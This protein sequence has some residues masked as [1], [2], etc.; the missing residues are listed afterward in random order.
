MKTMKK[1]ASLLLA[2]AMIFAL[3]TTAFA[4]DDVNGT[5]TIKPP[6]GIDDDALNTY[7]IY[8]VFDAAAHGD[9]ISYKRVT[10]K[11]DVPAGFNV[12]DAGNVT[13]AGAEGTTELTSADIAAIADYVKN[14]DPVAIVKSTGSANAVAENLGAG[15][16]YITTTTGTAVTITSGKPDAS[17]DDKNKVPTLNKEVL[18]DA[19][20]DGVVDAGETWGETNDANIGDKVQYKT[21]ITLQPNSKT[22]TMHDT[23]TDG[24]TFNEDVAIEGLTAG[25]DYNVT[26][27]GADGCTFD[28]AFTSTYLA[29]IKTETSVTVTYSAT[30]NEKAKISDEHN[31]NTAKL[32]YGEDN[33]YDTKPDTTETFSF[34]FD[35][36]KT[37]DKNN[38][39]NGAEFELY[40]AYDATK[41][42]YSNPISLVAEGDDYRVAKDGETGVTTIV[43]GADGKVNVKGLAK[44]TYYLKETKAPDGYN[45]L[46]TATTVNLTNG[47]LSA[48]FTDGKYDNGG[49]VVINKAGTELP[50]TG[51]MG[52]T[53]FYVLGGILVAAAAV[54]LVTKKRMAN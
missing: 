32:T 53:L 48:N 49:I 28:I 21:T 33:K 11:T 3:A 10:G 45:L 38:L 8:K 6:V 7:K 35:L 42:E 27:P 29:S 47:N 13:Y 30:L 54:L 14:D 9:N 12:D 50:S 2:L 34:K 26:K 20:H 40:G 5:I 25:T 18:I 23:M 4:A 1:L 39:L 24:L 44:G 19:D 15:Y 37:D 43:V 46:D 31:D 41:N 16:Y 36:V 17:V 51:G 52:T 22:A